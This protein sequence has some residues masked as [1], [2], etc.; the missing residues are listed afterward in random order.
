ML[1]FNFSLFCDQHLPPPTKKKGKK[2]KEEKEKNGHIL[3]ST[4][5]G[6][7]AMG[8]SP[9]NG[10]KRDTGA[11]WRSPKVPM[12]QESGAQDHVLATEVAENK[13]HDQHLMTWTHDDVDT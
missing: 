8:P 12:G 11:Q 10:P 7:Y 1:L 5:M 2:N 4:R 9:L 6:E 13:Q 3:Q